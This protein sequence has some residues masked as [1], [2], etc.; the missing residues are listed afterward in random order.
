MHASTADVTC[1]ITAAGAGQERAHFED[2][3]SKHCGIILLRSGTAAKLC[4]CTAE[5]NRRN[6]AEQ[7]VTVGDRC[8]AAE[9]QCKTKQIHCKQR[10]TIQMILPLIP[11]YQYGPVLRHQTA[12]Y[13]RLALRSIVHY[14]NQVQIRQYRPLYKNCKTVGLRRLFWRLLNVAATRVVS[15]IRF[16]AAKAP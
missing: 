14:C 2:T 4:S 8:R 1:S 7:N 11:V 13:D 3:A 12:N 6:P 15:L 9:N 5:Q 16:G 10:T